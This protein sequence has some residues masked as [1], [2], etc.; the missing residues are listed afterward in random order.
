VTDAKTT[1]TPG[2][3]AYAAYGAATDHLNYQGLPMPA[4]TELGDTIQRAWENAAAAVDGSSEIQRLTAERNRMARELA[5]LRDVHDAL[6]ERHAEFAETCG[7]HSADRAAEQVAAAL[8]VER[9]ENLDT[10]EAVKA[11]VRDYKAEITRIEGI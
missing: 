4:W 9:L 1:P 10:G 2:Q 11:A 8:L 3:V 6:R 5:D 7:V